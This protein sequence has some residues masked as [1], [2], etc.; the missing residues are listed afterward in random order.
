[1][2]LT[3]TRTNLTLKTSYFSDK[4]GWATLSL[5]FSAAYLW[6]VWKRGLPSGRATETCCSSSP[7]TKCPCNGLMDTF[8]GTNNHCCY[9]LILYSSQYRFQKIPNSNDLVPTMG[10][11]CIRITFVPSFNFT[12]ARITLI[13][14]AFL[15]ITQSTAQGHFSV[16]QLC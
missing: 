10:S 16:N 3:R 8:V 13:G 12:S 2:T 5:L 9:N 1:M 14:W 6:W 15:V 7:R 4:L 11:E